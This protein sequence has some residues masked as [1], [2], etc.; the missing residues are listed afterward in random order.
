MQNFRFPRL[1]LLGVLAAM[2]AS[3]SFARPGGPG[4]AGP[5]WGGPGW[6]GP[7]MGDSMAS[8][9]AASSVRSR[10]GEV[11][12]N[13][14]LAGDA[15]SLGHGTITIAPPQPGDAEGEE[16]A[17]LPTFESAALDRLA[18]QGYQTATALGSAG[19]LVEVRVLRSL[20][21]AEGAG[22]KPVSG[23]VAMGVS[24][25]GTMMGMAVNVDLSK[26][27]RALIATRL[28]VRIRDRAS[29]A[30]LWEGRAEAQ[31]REGD[32]RWAGSKLAIHLATALFDGFPGTSGETR[33]VK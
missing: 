30:V 6:G 15:A 22:H 3:P 28:E 11:E 23:E 25:R 16:D 19:Q 18:A 8:A 27:P 17:T 12:V 2:A 24:N 7:G 10:E 1:A 20:V 9:R 29:A 33:F 4:W 32:D 13:R 5:G 14:F 26:P 31:T 21:Q